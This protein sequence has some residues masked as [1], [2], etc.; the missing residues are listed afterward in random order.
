MVLKNVLHV[1][2]PVC[3]ECLPT[4]VP[5]LSHP[6]PPPSNW[7]SI[8]FLRALNW[9]FSLAKTWPLP[10]KNQTSKKEREIWPFVRPHS[11]PGLLSHLWPRE[12]P[13]AR[14]RRKGS[15]GLT[16]LLRTL[17]IWSF[18]AS[19]F[20]RPECFLP[21][22]MQLQASSILPSVFSEP[23]LHQTSLQ[24]QWWNLS[25]TWACLDSLL[26][27]PTLKKASKSAVLMSISRCQ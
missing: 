7:L 26:R 16:V 10:L 27:T 3:W 1:W 18:F 2:K 6:L 25:T 19:T 5:F 23:E 8:S 22:S 24:P 14:V 11:D 15:G 4:P 21:D 17:K 13:G 12:E 20:K 9:M